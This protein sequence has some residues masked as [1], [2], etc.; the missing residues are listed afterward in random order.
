[1]LAESFLRS[2]KVRDLH[3]LN[4]G[5]LL[6]VA[7]DRIS[8]FDVVLPSMIPDKGRVLTGFS[9]FWFAETAGIVPNHLLETDPGAFA[10][11]VAEDIRSE[12]YPP[13]DIGSL[14]ELRGRMMICRPADV[15]PIE[16]VVRGYLAGSGWKEYQA[17]GTVCGIPLPPG[18]RESD[19][20]PE[21]IFTPATKAEQGEHDEN[22]T[23]DGMIEH[24]AGGSLAATPEQPASWPRRSA[25]APS[26]CTHTPSAVAARRGIL[27]ADTKFEFG[28]AEP[29]PRTRGPRTSFGDDDPRIHLDH[30]ILID[31]AL[32]PDSSRFWD[33]ASYEPGRPQASFDKQFVRDWLETQPWD[34]T[35]P[36][37]ELPDDVI[38][39]TR[40]RYIEAYE[41]ITGASFERYLQEDVIAS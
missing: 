21:P 41:R 12:G 38:D 29:W 31:E 23:F 39:G 28:L 11:Y 2:G 14:D 8:A 17:S 9:R 22:I 20:L 6:L 32:T 10:E 18:L 34:K 19:R 16:A 25:T 40:A 37:P 30:L 3:M 35:A 4:D 5:R 26:A 13:A 36:G 24:I 1:M 33:A 27:L 7:S 15:V